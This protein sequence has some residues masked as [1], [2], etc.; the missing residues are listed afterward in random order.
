MTTAPSRQVFRQT[1]R[2]IARLF[3]R[4]GIEAGGGGRRWQGAAM[5]QAPQTAT[6]AARGPAKARAS[7]L[8]TNSAHANRIV[9]HWT[10]AL[11]GR[12]WHARSQHPDETERRRLSDDF[13]AL[14]GPIMAGLARAVVRDGEAF[15]KLEA[16]ADGALRLRLLPADQVDPSLTRELGGGA[17]IVAGVEF[18]AEERVVAYHVLRDSPGAP[19][20]IGG[21]GEA[22]RVPAV[23]MLHVFD[24]L[25]PGQVRGLSWLSPVLLKLRDREEASDAMLM[26]AKVASLVTG[27]IQDPEGGT[28]GFEGA[29]DGETVNVSLEP[30]AMRILP[31]GTSV[32]FS[33][34]PAGLAQAVDFL[35]AQDREIA[36]GAGLTY[37]ALTGDL[38]D[39]N[40]SSARVGLLDFRRRAEMLQRSLIEGQFLRPLWRRWVELQAL[41]GTIPDA[42]LPDYRAVRF[43]APGWQWVD[44][45]KEVAAEVA[46]IEAGIKSRAEV[47]AARGRD[48]EE[49]DAER[50]ADRQSTGGADA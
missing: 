27:Y 26:Q 32:N 25:F 36:A 14:V 31:A 20:A 15:V 29:P 9:E 10:A 45:Q 30:G 4:S 42:E 24:P 38:A 39:A 34:P 21:V 5:L 8:Y 46:A 28:G 33:N 22:V 1:A 48:L 23:D 37:E 16:E 6:L 35:K 2:R 7:G 41:A 50:A 13:E 18:D 11:V 40:Y 3:R 44:P 17:R 49:L 19:F 12:G 47:V 43:V